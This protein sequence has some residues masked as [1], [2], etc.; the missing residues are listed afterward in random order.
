M[1]SF[2]QPRTIACTAI[3]LA[4]AIEMVAIPHAN[5]QTDTRSEYVQTSDLDLTTDRGRSVLDRRIRSAAQRVCTGD[6]DTGSLFERRAM[7][8]CVKSAIAGAEKARARAIAHALQY[9][10]AGV[11]LAVLADPQRVATTATAFSVAT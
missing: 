6:F 7:S 3:A 8:G 4:F 10:G 9:P 11:P 5:A 2:L 1:L